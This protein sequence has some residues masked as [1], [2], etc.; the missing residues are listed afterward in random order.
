ML[1]NLIFKSISIILNRLFLYRYIIFTVSIIF[2]FAA[3]VNFLN[4]LFFDKIN[5][6]GDIKYFQ[7][8]GSRLSSRELNY[9]YEY[10]TKLPL[11]QYI[12]WFI[13]VTTGDF[14]L[15]S[16]RIINFVI[17]LTCGIISLYFIYLYYSIKCNIKFFLNLISFIFFFL[18]FYLLILYILP[19]SE[20]SHIEILAANFFLLG[21]SLWFFPLKKKILFTF[22]SS[23]A[24]AFSIHVRPNYL[25]AVPFFFFIDF[26]N[27]R[28]L[29]IYFYLKFKNNEFNLF[30]YL[31]KNIYL[32]KNFFIFCIGL[33]C[34][35]IL[36]F[37][38]YLF[39]RNG[40][41]SLL[42]GILSLKNIQITQSPI[43]VLEA[44][45]LGWGS[46]FFIF[47]SFFLIS[48]FVNL[49]IF[50]TF[51]K[52]ITKNFSFILFTSINFM[53]LLIQ[54]SVFRTHYYDH[55]SI[56]L[57]PF[58]LV[59]FIII[60]I[61]SLSK[62]Y[63]NFPIKKFY[64][65][66][67]LMVS[68]LILVLYPIYFATKNL[69][70]LLFNYNNIKITK[71]PKYLDVHLLEFL[72]SLKYQKMSF[73]VYDDV[74]YHLILNE[75]RIGDVGPV[76]LQDVFLEQ[77]V[78]FPINQIYIFSEEV[79]KNPCLSLY[80]SKKDIIVFNKKNSTHPRNSIILSCVLKKNLYYEKLSD[81]TSNRIL[82]DKSKYYN[83]NNFI[84]FIKK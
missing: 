51:I 77:S 16:W 5:E 46:Y 19:G 35:T 71:Y 56:M 70:F 84:I 4:Y 8:L 76:I 59:I 64:Y 29:C 75:K 82:F 31:L 40:L 62:N 9:I 12:F 81:Q 48:V 53:V 32:F 43:E 80:N 49:I 65:N 39:I 54:L 13:N 34:F 44:Q 78:N 15:T 3:I 60:T 58:L 66:K 69:K 30:K 6:N 41:S 42:A 74:S 28:N 37:L 18:S 45:F 27:Q 20:V 50:F 17:S 22:L 10:E 47:H 36:T 67:L 7:Y 23:M 52:S 83:I 25:F 33:S 14:S 24:I 63:K 73:Y 68:L 79:R 61:P 57:V 21:F 11:V 26:Y 2:L 1:N 55:H 72:K 38:P